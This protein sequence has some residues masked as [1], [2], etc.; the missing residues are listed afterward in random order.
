MK[1]SAEEKENPNGIKSNYPV[2]NQAEK[3]RK[4]LQKI[5]LETCIN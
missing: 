2:M 5:K 3:D 4:T 1:I